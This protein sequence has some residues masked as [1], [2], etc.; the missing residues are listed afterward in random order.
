MDSL[1]EKAESGH[2]RICTCVYVYNPRFSDTPLPP[3]PFFFKNEIVIILSKI[4]VH[5]YILRTECGVRLNLMV[6]KVEYLYHRHALFSL[7]GAT[8][9]PRTKRLARSLF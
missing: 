8:S 5:S 7:H 2:V 3:P 1:E 9:R 6:N 4:E